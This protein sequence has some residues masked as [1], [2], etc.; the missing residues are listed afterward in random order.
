MQHSHSLDDSPAKL[1]KKG[2]RAEE[3]AASLVLVGSGFG[4]QHLSLGFSEPCLLNGRLLP[5]GGDGAS[6]LL[7]THFLLQYFV[8]KVVD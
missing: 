5:K 3:E 1:A 4:R 8:V 7:Q 2:A 6:H